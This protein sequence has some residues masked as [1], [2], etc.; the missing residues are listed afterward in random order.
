MA[1]DTTT[2]GE[3]MDIATEQKP[4]LFAASSVDNNKATDTSAAVTKSDSMKTLEYHRQVLQN[5]MEIEYVSLLRLPFFKYNSANTDHVHSHTKYVSPSDNIMS[6]CTAKLSAF[7]SKQAGKY[8]YPSYLPT[9]TDVVFFTIFLSVML[10]YHVFLTTGSSR[11]RSSPK[12]LLR[13]SRARRPS[14]TQAP[15]PPL[16]LPT[17]VFSES[18]M[19]KRNYSVASTSFV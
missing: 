17:P 11:S 5:K 18:R 4:V 10:T 2:Q 1:M 3:P 9:R 14:A 15:P 12:R 13:N 7:R 16:A 8:V 19:I 6:P